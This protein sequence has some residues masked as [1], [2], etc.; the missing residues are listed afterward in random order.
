MSGEFGTR[1]RC[2]RMSFARAGER[3]I[4]A[5][6]GDILQELGPIESVMSTFS[7]RSRLG[8]CEIIPLAMGRKRRDML[9]ASLQGY[10]GQI[11]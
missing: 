11:G 6:S 3:W 9:A 10:R 2:S 1:D 8:C 5:T 7:S 4:H